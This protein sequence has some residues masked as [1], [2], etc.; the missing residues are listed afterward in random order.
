MVAR[1]RETPTPVGISESVR[2]K[3]FVPRSRLGF[4]PSRICPLDLTDA[5]CLRTMAGAPR[6]ILTA[7]SRSIFLPHGGIAGLNPGNR[8]GVHMPHSSMRVGKISSN[9]SNA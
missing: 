6:T 2:R 1:I 7:R 4:V 3:R 9:Q 8:L 5:S